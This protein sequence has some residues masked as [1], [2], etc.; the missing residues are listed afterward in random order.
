M[1]IQW[2][3]ADPPAAVL[4]GCLFILRVRSDVPPTAEPVPG[5]ISL[6]WLS[7]ILVLWPPHT[8]HTCVR[9]SLTQCTEPDA[10]GWQMVWDVDVRRDQDEGVIVDWWSLGYLPQRVSM[11]F[12][13]V[14][15]ISGL[16]FLEYFYK[17]EEWKFLL[18]RKVKWFY[19]S[20]INLF[21]YNTS[22]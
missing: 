9:R 3:N 19:K 4:H 8:P 5:P 11:Q 13:T 18:V 1:L 17:E 14:C 16:L 20:L 6:S 7:Q 15:R 2:R 12:G 10:Q 21:V 22:F